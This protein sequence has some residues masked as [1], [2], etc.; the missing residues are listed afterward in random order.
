M[1]AEG[2]A[3]TLESPGEDVPATVAGR[4]AGYVRG[5]GI[6]TPLI[7]ALLPFLIGVLGFSKGVARPATQYQLALAPVP[8]APANA[9]ARAALTTVPGGTHVRLW[10]NNL[11]AD[12]VYEFQLVAPPLRVT[13]GVGSPLNPIAIK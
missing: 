7:T 4:L 9:N 5:G 10:V 8:G 11:A 3:P 12:G 13:G 6:I 1:S 2:P